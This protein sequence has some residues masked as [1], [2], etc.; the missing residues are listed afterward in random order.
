MICESRNATVTTA[1]PRIT[2]SSQWCGRQFKQQSSRGGLCVITDKPEKLAAETKCRCGQYSGAFTNKS[3]CFP[4]SYP[5]S[6]HFS[7]LLLHLPPNFRF[8]F[9]KQ[10]REQFSDIPDEDRTPGWP[11][12]DRA[13]VLFVDEHHEKVKIGKG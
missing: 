9:A 5:P 7:P 12:L 6:H 4:L 13:Q 10:L 1:S 8:M 11:K 2:L 3:R